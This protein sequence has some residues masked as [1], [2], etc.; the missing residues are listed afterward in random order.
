MEH[1]NDPIRNTCLSTQELF[2]LIYKYDK[3]SRR[4]VFREPFTYAI[5]GLL[6]LFNGG[7]GLDAAKAAWMGGRVMG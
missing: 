6:S 5:N 2:R 3:P 1:L 4:L 7:E